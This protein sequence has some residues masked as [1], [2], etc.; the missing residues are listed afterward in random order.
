M[1]SKL[2]GLAT[3]ALSSV[4]AFRATPNEERPPFRVFRQEMFDL[5]SD[6]ERRAQRDRLDPGRD[7]FLA[8]VALIDETVLASDWD[9]AE[10]WRNRTLAME[11]LD[12]ETRT[13]D[14]FFDRLEKLQRG[15]QPDVLEIYFACLCAGF[16]GKHFDDAGALRAIQTRLYQRLV[17]EDPRE[18]G[19]L[20]PDAYGRDL[21]RPMITRRFPIYWAL[22]FVLGAVGLYA[23]YYLVLTRQADDI[24]RE[25]TAEF[26]WSQGAPQ[27]R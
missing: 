4:F 11:M 19:R 7:A 3:D 8:L 21:E 1:N 12:G 16:R 22:P 5:L 26:R 25:T 13:G 10:D 17:E 23:A 14:L 2:F 9:E 6:F 18:E 27:G 15:D 20:T 24:S